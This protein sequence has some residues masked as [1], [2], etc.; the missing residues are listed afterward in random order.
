MM[1]QFKSKIAVF[2][3]AIAMA[4]V[5]LSAVGAETKKA[6]TPP[7]ERYT[8]H[9]VY[10]PSLTYTYMGHFTL[11]AGN[12]YAWAFGKSKDVKSGRYSYDAA[13]GIRFIDGPLKDIKG[14]FET[15]KD[16]RHT[17]DMKIQGEKKYES[18]DGILTWYGNCDPHDPYEKKKKD[19]K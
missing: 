18:D 6:K 13:K 12:K 2:S 19:K 17:F 14:T 7:L 8:C 4:A 3:I 5:S 1:N 15:G 11:K 10:A 9:Q 16:G